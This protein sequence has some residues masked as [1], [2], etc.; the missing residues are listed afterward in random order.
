M[1]SRRKRSLEEIESELEEILKEKN[2][3]LTD[4]KVFTF[5]YETFP[6]DLPCY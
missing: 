4:P 1:N 3:A 5:L 6:L 2:V